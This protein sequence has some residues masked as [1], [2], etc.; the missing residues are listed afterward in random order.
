ML[1]Y[2]RWKG[3]RFDKLELTNYTVLLQY[4][5]NYTRPN[6][7]Q[8]QN[9]TGGVIYNA[10]IQQEKPLTPGENDS[11]VAP[12]FNA[13]SGNGNATVSGERERL[14]WCV[15]FPVGGNDGSMAILVASVC[16]CT[17]VLVGGRM[18]VTVLC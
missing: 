2:N 11:S 13:Y 8:L 1:V 15:L 5:G 6:Q 14:S 7:L 10:S 16:T 4:P 9:S 3:Y 12:P 18:I 17:C